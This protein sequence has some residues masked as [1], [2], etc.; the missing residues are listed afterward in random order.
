MGQ[1][2]RAA[3]EEFAAINGVVIIIKREKAE[4]RAAIFKQAV[5]V[6]NF[7]RGDLLLIANPNTIT[8]EIAEGFIYVFDFGFKTHARSVIKANG[9]FA[10]TVP[11]QTDIPAIGDAIAPEH[12]PALRPVPDQP[13]VPSGADNRRPHSRPVKD[14]RLCNPI[15]ARRKIDRFAHGTA[16]QRR[17]QRRRII[18]TAITDCRGS[19]IGFDINPVRARLPVQARDVR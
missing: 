18:R 14:Q 17:L 19:H 15:G 4:R 11:D 16:I 9:R 7:S 5:V 8:G 12:P 3:V 10:A 1:H 13:R 2:A 6:E